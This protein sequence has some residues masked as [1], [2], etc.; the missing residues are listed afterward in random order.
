MD[1]GEFEAKIR[2]ILPGADIQ[3][4]NYGQIVVYTNKAV[5]VGTSQVV[6]FDSNAGEGTYEGEDYD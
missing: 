3:T 5:L 4:D 6:E 2:S 1:F